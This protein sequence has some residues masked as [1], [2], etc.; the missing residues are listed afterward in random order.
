MSVKFAGELYLTN[1]SSRLGVP[2]ETSVKLYEKIKEF[3]NIMGLDQRYGKIDYHHELK[4]NLQNFH[5]DG[6]KVKVQLNREEPDNNIKQT[7]KEAFQQTLAKHLHRQTKAKKRK[8]SPDSSKQVKITECDSDSNDSFKSVILVKDEPIVQQTVEQN[9]KDE[10]ILPFK[11][12]ISWFN[13]ELAELNNQVLNQN[14]IIKEQKSEIL[15][16]KEQNEELRKNFF[17]QGIQLALNKQQNS[18]LLREREETINL[19]KG[20]NS[21]FSI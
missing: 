19:I 6:L 3:L 17:D 21:H 11:K 4:D 1:V 13:S 18:D 5:F 7:N 8:Y 10:V 2:V 20:L 9:E 16:L 14:K 12:Q 15:K